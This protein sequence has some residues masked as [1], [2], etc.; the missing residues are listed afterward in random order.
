M[1]RLLHPDRLHDFRSRRLLH[2][3][4]RRD[5][6]AGRGRLSRAGHRHG[7]L[8]IRSQ[9]GR[10]AVAMGELDVQLRVKAGLRA[11]RLDVVAERGVNAFR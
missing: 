7:P 6:W 10:N 8:Q 2:R 4:R 9:K 11:D 3:G 1:N 5:D